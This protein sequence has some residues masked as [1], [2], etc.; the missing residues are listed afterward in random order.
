[1]RV[2]RSLRSIEC[3]SSS[4]ICATGST[5][6]F[7]LGQVVVGGIEVGIADGCVGGIL[8]LFPPQEE[9]DAEAD[10]GY[11]DEATEDDAAE[12][13]PAEVGI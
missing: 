10:G 1:M 13:G 9:Q 2:V 3:S 4:R 11:D 12:G 7:Q 5:S 6:G 8:L